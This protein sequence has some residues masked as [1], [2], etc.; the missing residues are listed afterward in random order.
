MLPFYGS[1]PEAFSRLEHSTRRSAPVSRTVG[2]EWLGS[3]PALP[4]IPAKQKLGRVPGGQG[5]WGCPPV[6]GILW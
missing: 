6:I 5:R 4:W 1:V 3:T 2:G